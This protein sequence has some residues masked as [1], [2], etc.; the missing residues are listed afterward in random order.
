MAELTL[1]A[2][3]VKE[4]IVE[5]GIAKI[6][7][8]LASRK[9][10][11]LK[12]IALKLLKMLETGHEKSDGKFF[13]LTEENPQNV[14]VV[15]KALSNF[16]LLTTLT[17]VVLKRGKREELV[18]VFTRGSEK[19]NFLLVIEFFV[20]TVMLLCLFIRCVLILLW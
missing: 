1:N 16:L 15:E 6:P 7:N 4:S 9:E 12:I 5:C 2:G 17:G 8:K 18:H 10:T 19:I 20:I 11:G 14:L 13:V 3:S